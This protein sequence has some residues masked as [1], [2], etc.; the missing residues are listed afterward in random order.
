[1]ALMSTTP[2]KRNSDSVDTSQEL[3]EKDGE[4][5]LLSTRCSSEQEPSL[6]NH[7]GEDIAGLNQRSLLTAMA[8]HNHAATYKNECNI[9]VDSKGEP[10][11]S[12]PIYFQSLGPSSASSQTSGSWTSSAS[13]SSFTSG[14]STSLDNSIRPINQGNLSPLPTTTQGQ[15]SVGSE[16]H[17]AGKCRPCLFAF[18]RMGCLLG[19]SCKYC[20]LS[21]ST[22]DRL[23]KGGP[24]EEVPDN[25]SSS[26]DEEEYF[27]KGALTS[28]FGT[29][30]G[31]WNLV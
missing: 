1:M 26:S 30:E 13:S 7:E 29:P 22:K 2:A 28:L 19:A 17:D 18:S 10:G 21:H 15:E 6:E 27:S 24:V 23:K 25:A 8:L 31:V 3:G 4:S 16:L 11:N 14:S 20:H 5:A 9:Y 12:L